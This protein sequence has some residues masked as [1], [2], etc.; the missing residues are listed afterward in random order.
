MEHAAWHGHRI[1]FDVTGTGPAV[2]LQHGLLS[3]RSTWHANGFVAALAAGFTVVAVD[4]LG[5]GESDKPGDPAAYRRDARADQLAA[6]LDAL[7]LERAHVVGYS[8]G[9]WLAAGFAAR[10]PGRLLSVTIGGWDPV[11]GRAAGVAFDTVLASVRARAPEL[12]AWVRAEYEPGLRACWDAL[13]DVEGA[14]WALRTCLAP[15]LLWAGREDPVHDGARALA[16]RLPG[17]SFCAVPG[18]HLG[19]MTVHAGE[20]IAALRDFLRRP[21][22]PR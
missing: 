15:V 9:G 20:S 22:Y 10:H 2:L 14:E 16:A 8:M 19:A 7:A 21:P 3:G 17:A 13:A 1:A 18:D 11:A 12:A 6:V 4:S 5:H